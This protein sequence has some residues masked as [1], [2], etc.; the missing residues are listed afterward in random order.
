MR[1]PQQ[2]PPVAR[3]LSRL[4][5]EAAQGHVMPSNGLFSDYMDVFSGLGNAFRP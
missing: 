1:I 3:T 2:A 4:A 5:Q